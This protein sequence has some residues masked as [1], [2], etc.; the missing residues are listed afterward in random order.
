MSKALSSV[1]VIMRT[2]VLHRHS[3]ILVFIWFGE[4]KTGC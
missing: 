4:E 3:L 1:T 2:I